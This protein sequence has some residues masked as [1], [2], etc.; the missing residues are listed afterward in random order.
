MT[1]TWIGA[2]QPL[3]V[4][5]CAQNRLE[6]NLP[7]AWH[8][9]NRIRKMYENKFTCMFT[10]QGH[11]NLL[12]IIIFH[13]LFDP[14]NGFLPIV[15]APE[16]PWCMRH[17]IH[18]PRVVDG[19]EFHSCFI[20]NYVN[21]TSTLYHFIA[22]SCRFFNP[23]SFRNY[24]PVL[25]V[26]IIS[27]MSS[28][29]TIHVVEDKQKKMVIMTSTFNIIYLDDQRRMLYPSSCLFMYFSPMMV[30]PLSLRKIS[31]SVSLLDSGWRNLSVSIVL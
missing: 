23:L 8:F 22:D 17:K 21:I 7:L 16:R 6:V 4:S 24:L 31:A 5:I 14:I 20:L 29:L 19:V 10:G 27:L 2:L 12:F 13:T 18:G 25:L 30:V 3:L 11:L 1:E 15:A 28:Q 26:S 9:W